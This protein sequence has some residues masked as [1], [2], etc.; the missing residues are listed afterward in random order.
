MKYFRQNT[1]FASALTPFSPDPHLL[2]LVSE[3]E[4]SSLEQKLRMWKLLKEISCDFISLQ[5]F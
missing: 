1:S 2:A 4:N 5:D 3:T